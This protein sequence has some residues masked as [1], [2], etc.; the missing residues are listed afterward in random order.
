MR[1]I[2]IVD[3]SLIDTRGHHY[4]LT[5][6]I[7][8][9]IRI[10]GFQA[11]WFVNLC[12]KLKERDEIP[13]LNVFSSS[14]YDAYIIKKKNLSLFRRILGKIKH[15]VKINADHN[16]KEE[17]MAQQI[18]KGIDA[19]NLGPDDKLLFHTADAVTYSAIHVLLNE[20]EIDRIPV[21][22]ICTPYDPD[23][24][25][26]NRVNNVEIADI[27]RNWKSGGILDRKIYL[28]A[29]N[30]RLAAVFGV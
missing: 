22:Y 3:P 12:S 5:R 26:P 30:Y 25:M 14:L 19:F 11:I 8:E 20:Y 6:R 23:G 27:I 9:S 21:I 7:T 28:F 13:I 1:R 2:A 4:E 15:A 29:E 10:N 18:L 24:I 17:V 16:A